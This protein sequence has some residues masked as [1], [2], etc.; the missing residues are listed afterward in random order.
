MTPGVTYLFLLTATDSK[1]NYLFYRDHEV[2]FGSK[3]DSPSDLYEEVDYRT[4]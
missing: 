2:V 4:D 3:P 1:G